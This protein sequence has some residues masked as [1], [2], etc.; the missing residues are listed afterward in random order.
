MSRFITK[1]HIAIS[2]IACSTALYA[3]QTIVAFERNLTLP[4]Q[5]EADQVLEMP[6]T[7]GYNYVTA[8]EIDLNQDGIQDLILFDRSGDRITPMLW[9][10][11]TYEF[12][13]EFINLIPPGKHFMQFRDLNC[14]GK[15]DIFT[16]SDGGFKVYKNTSSL[17]EGLKFELYTESLMSFYN[18]GTLPIY[19]IPVDV[20]AIE[21]MDG[22]G[23][24]DILVFGILGTCV[25]YHRNMAVEQLSRCDTLVFRLESN[26]WGNFT[27]ALSTNQVILNDSCDALGGRYNQSERHAGSSMLAIDMNGDGDKDLVLGDIAYR[28]MI[29][30]SNGGTQ[31]S[32][33]VTDQVTPWPANTTFV[34]LPVFPAASYVDI[35]HDGNRDL[36]VS[37]NAEGG[38]ENLRCM[39][40]YQ[41][42]GSDDSPVFSFVQNSLF[43]DKSLDFGEGSMPTFC[44]F[45]KD[46]LKDIIVGN[47]GYFES[48][49]SYRP[50][51][52]LFENIGTPSNPSYKLVTNDLA[53]LSML[54]GNALNFF[55]TLGDVD[56]DDDDDLLIGASDGRIFYYINTAPAGETAAFSFITPSFQNID[57]GTFAA[58][59]LADIDADGLLDLL[60]GSRE[61]R[62]HYYHNSGSPQ[63]MILDF[64]TDEFGNVSTSLPGEP[65]GFS[66]P[67]FF[68]KSGISYLMCG[69][70]NGGISLYSGIDGN[71]DGN[72]IREDSL[73]LGNRIGERTTITVTDLNADGFLDAIVGN[74]AGGINYFQG[75]FPT[76]TSTVKSNNSGIRIYPNP[77]RNISIASRDAF[78]ESIQIFDI[79]GRI[80]ETISVPPGNTISQIN[81][82]N[83]TS[84][85]YFIL[86][87]TNK[88]TSTHKW[89]NN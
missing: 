7:G 88:G 25:E 35:D 53:D 74:Y 65:S 20:P 5:D 63:N 54:S 19:A 51:L 22:D 10:S 46:G 33:N 4:F 56:G 47:Y 76:N 55:P 44:D 89:L 62:I 16:Y 58:P 43:I 29:L 77:S 27:E 83:Y 69:S 1:I 9:N 67:C 15:A 41:N 6:L 23:D 78:I 60:V 84:G 39:W 34:N 17:A 68:K 3:Q 42:I 71:L 18:P 12:A 79:Q 73:V 86:A 2:I 49:G 24:L 52:A 8:G 57:I 59:Q 14:D 70:Q 21:D 40:Y 30:L 32:A 36:L 50:Q 75:V 45:N 82:N 28:T 13:P 31:T 37:P 48:N 26:N 64:V 87:K 81:G 66:T 72:F 38:S 61:G 11:T 85:L 80:I